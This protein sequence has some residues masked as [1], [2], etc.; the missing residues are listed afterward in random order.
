[1]DGLFHAGLRYIFVAKSMNAPTVGN[2]YQMCLKKNHR[3][4]IYE[5]MQKTANRNVRRLQNTEQQSFR[6]P[7]G[8]LA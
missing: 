1:M 2:K 4:C 7:E 3:I 8:L 6:T 5:Y